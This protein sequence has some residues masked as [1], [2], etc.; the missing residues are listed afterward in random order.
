MND[1]LRKLITTEIAE[2]LELNIGHQIGL[3]AVNCSILRADSTQ[4]ARMRREK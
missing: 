2:Y 1:G 4:E 3:L